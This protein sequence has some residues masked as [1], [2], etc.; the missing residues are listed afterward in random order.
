MLLDDFG[1]TDQGCFNVMVRQRPSFDQDFCVGFRD[2]YPASL[3]AI[4][5]V[6]SVDRGS[7][8]ER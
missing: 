1:P 5:L 3:T 2:S 4:G 8:D 6:F 7:A